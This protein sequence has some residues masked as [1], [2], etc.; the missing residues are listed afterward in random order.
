[1][2]KN[3]SGVVTVEAAIFLAVVTIALVA[4]FATLADELYNPSY[5]VTVDAT[6]QEL[7]V[8]AEGDLPGIIQE[9]IQRM[10]LAIG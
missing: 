6:T 9:F 8:D 1:M 4:G 10:N 3:K 7:K 2:M 5:D